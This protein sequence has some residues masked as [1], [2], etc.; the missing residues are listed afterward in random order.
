MRP[1]VVQQPTTSPRAHKPAQAEIVNPTDHAASLANGAMATQGED[2]TSPASLNSPR[3]LGLATQCEGIKGFSVSRDSRPHPATSEQDEL[4]GGTIAVQQQQYAQQRG[5]ERSLDQHA[6]QPSH[7]P[8]EHQFIKGTTPAC[9][10][11]QV[12]RYQVPYLQV[13]Y[14]PCTLSPRGEDARRDSLA[15]P[16]HMCASVSDWREYLATHARPTLVPWEIAQQLEAERQLAQC[17]TPVTTCLTSGR[18]WTSEPLLTQVPPD[19]ANV[20]LPPETAE[21]REMEPCPPPTLPPPLAVASPSPQ[22]TP[23]LGVPSYAPPPPVPPPAMGCLRLHGGGIGN[24]SQHESPPPGD[25]PAAPPLPEPP[26]DLPPPE[27]PPPWSKS[28][29]TS[30]GPPR[31]SPAAWV[32]KAH[33]SPSTTSCSTASPRPRPRL[34]AMPPSPVPMGSLDAAPSSPP[35]PSMAQ[36]SIPFAE[37]VPTPRHSRLRPSLRA[38]AV[39]GLICGCSGM[40]LDREGGRESWWQHAVFCEQSLDHAAAS[41]AWRR[42]KGLARSREEREEFLASPEWPRLLSEECSRRDTVCPPKPPPKMATNQVTSPSPKPQSQGLPNSPL[43]QDQPVESSIE[44]LKDMLYSKYGN[45]REVARTTVQ[46]SRTLSRDAPPHILCDGATSRTLADF[47]N[48]ANPNHPRPSVTEPGPIAYLALARSCTQVCWT[49][50]FWLWTRWETWTKVRLGVRRRWTRC[51]RRRTWVRT[52]L[53]RRRMWRR[54]WPPVDTA[55]S[56]TRKWCPWTRLRSRPPAAA[57]VLIQVPTALPRV[58]R[59]SAEPRAAPRNHERRRRG[60]RRAWR[61]SL[62]PRT[63]DR[64]VGVGCDS[65]EL[66]H[67]R[68]AYGEGPG[69]SRSGPI[70]IR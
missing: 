50:L 56:A 39:R 14:L 31:P 11:C 2:S 63:A 5:A 64:R 19:P 52:R 59:S 36:Q 67:A 45:L 49:P 15:R 53:F 57:A 42:A 40:Y 70:S 17:S 33:H 66:R 22:I 34:L 46:G 9:T 16:P 23:E 68:Q 35:Q 48:A 43:H 20:K 1:R 69:R 6:A 32:Q 25:H 29:P 30:P 37:C 12:N 65:A 51:L 38:D 26:P 28:I 62:P 7:E 61:S 60:E 55:D 21:S 44:A 3:P 18:Q 41:A 8:P 58:V 10:A 47:P 13:P 54:T 4:R 27:P 24:L